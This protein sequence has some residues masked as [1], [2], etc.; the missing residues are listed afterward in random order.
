M[1]FKLKIFWG[2][3]FFTLFNSVYAQVS[4][5]EKVCKDRQ[6]QQTERCE[7]GAYCEVLYWPNKNLGFGHV[8]LEIYHQSQYPNYFPDIYLSWAMGNN[9]RTDL[10]KHEMEPERIKLPTFS[11]AKFKEVK[12]WFEDS[13]Y[14]RIFD[15]WEEYGMEYS[16]LNHNC[17]HAVWDGLKQCGYKLDVSSHWGLRPAEIRDAALKLVPKNH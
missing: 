9:I 6:L 3:I 4:S 13:H 5:K 15:K 14:R 8:A 10:R 1:N 17:A 2:L 12:K 11:L 16:M 7:Q